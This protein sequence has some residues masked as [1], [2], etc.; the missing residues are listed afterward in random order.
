[1]V[2]RELLG[3]AARCAATVGL[4]LALPALPAAASTAPG[5]SLRE[6]VGQR[7]V[8]AMEGTTPSASML[9]RVRS[10]EVG[11]VILFGPNVRSPAQVR[12]LTRVLHRAA[13]DG[14]VPRLLIAVDQEG[15]DFRR[16]RWAPPGLAAAALGTR[17]PAALERVGAAT[18]RALRANG[19][20][21]DLAPVADVPSRPGSFIATQERA[22]G[23][24]PAAVG[25][26]AAA[27]ATGLQSAGVAATAKHFP[28]LG[29][30]SRTTDVAAVTVRATRAQLDA[31]LAPF[32]ALVLA[33]VGLVMISNATYTAL[34]PEPAVW[35]P[36]TYRLLRRDLGFAG[37]TVTDALEAVAASERRGVDDAA[38][39]AAV[40]GAD[41]LL[42][43]GGERESAAVFDS[44]LRAAREGRL[45]RAS[46][47]RSYGRVLALKQVTGPA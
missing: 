16:L 41:L 39:R 12:A 4:V 20:D 15:G 13:R 28:G 45:P 34:G 40:A 32:R 11:G 29:R 6:L 31:D 18:G 47:E 37:V 5:V 30:A 35:S 43:A 14:G 33:G 7:L 38:L 24:V 3:T 44:L 2:P 23:T 17:S 36:A 46:L 19:I 1:M 10:G 9:A 42:L 21:V 27:F 25:A 8:V 22:F 26:R